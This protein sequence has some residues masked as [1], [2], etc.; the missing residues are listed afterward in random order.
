MRRILLLALLAGCASSRRTP[1]PSPDG[2][3]EERPRYLTRLT[4]ADDYGRVQGEGGEVKWLAPAPGTAPLL[5]ADC[6]FQD[7]AR[8]PGHITFLKSFPALASLDFDAYLSLLLK[9][10]SRRLWG[11]ALKL[12][13]GAVH[14]R[15]GARGLLAYFA[16]A[17][18]TD[19]DALTPDE[20]AKIDALLKEKIPYARDLL[21]LVGMDPDQRQRFDAIKS[22][23]AGRGVDLV[24][25]A[26]LEPSAAA[27]GYS[28]GESYGFLRVVPAG[29]RPPDDYGPRDLLVVEGAPLDIG[30]V[31]GLLTVLP[32]NIHSHVNLRLREKH[33][34]NARLPD[35]YMNQ[36]VSLLDGKLVHLTVE[37]GAVTL[38]P[39]LADS[40]QAF[41]SKT[42]PVAPPLHADLTEAR[43]R[44]L[45]SLRH[46]DSA[47]YGGKAAN[48]GELSVVLPAAN[49]VAGGFAIPF[50]VYRDYMQSSGAQAHLM[51]LLA[52]PAFSADAQYR[53]NGL[54]A[55][56][57]SIQD[58][59][60][61]AGLLV[62]LREAAQS[63]FGAGYAQMPVRFRSSSN[64]ED[65]EEVSGAGLNDSFRGCFADDDDGD[66]VG[67]SR[68]LA[69]DE[70]A[71]MTAELAR[72]Q[73]ES[74]AHPDRYW[75]PDIIDGLRKDL[76][77]ERSVARALRNV[78]ASL[79]NER[80]FEERAYYSVDQAS[81][82]MAVA[83]E[84]SFV[85]EKLDA[86][87]LTNLD[88]G[89]GGAPLYRVVSQRDGQ[90]VVRPADPT[91]VAETLTFRR[92]AADAVTDV[93]VPILSSLSSG[94]LWTDAQLA[95]LGRLL[96]AAHD[97]LLG[98]YPPVP[99]RSFDLEIKLTSDDRI[100]IK[101]I[102]PYVDPGPQP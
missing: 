64:V 68:C 70:R 79:W 48:L 42:H 31:A 60:L 50:S 75:L 18:D 4:T 40:A 102:R 55:L 69:D 38:D 53:R 34:P 7:T 6:L 39:A 10:P 88:P 99:R 32:Q 24:T 57:K 56:R 59:E 47:A 63:A 54:A 9:R 52:D 13:S 35:A 1:S 80:A 37:A 77:N 23:L 51:N 71:W 86:V 8:Y 87:A 78:F 5:P 22:D 19:V 85:L 49:Q 89:D 100:V 44:P 84:P 62:R 94:P 36:V 14:P 96:F 12:F 16:Y 15:T 92:G 26:D 61:P 72:R 28:L 95:E 74:A 66:E 21:V 90:G 45:S 101:Q 17:D 41:W 73:E 46:G 67:P 65:G 81:A 27:E 29:A 3:G 82:Y 25:P 11:G 83:V 76:T 91:L 98:V 43:L 20:L 93:Q 97:H 2:G 58:G 33:I 30:L